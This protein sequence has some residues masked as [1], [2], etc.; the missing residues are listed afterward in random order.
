[1]EKRLN[2][3]IEQY[4][5]EFKNNIRNKVSSL[6]FTET[7]KTNELIEY[8]YDYTRLQ[9]KK[10]DLSKRLRIKNMIPNVNRCNAKRC[11]GEQCTRRRKTDS[12]FCGTHI[13]GTPHGLIL[14]DSNTTAV[15]QKVDVYAKEIYGIMYY[16]DNYGNI[17]KTEDIL[18]ERQNPQI[19]AK[20]VVENDIYKIPEFD[21]L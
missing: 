12:T 6:A 13:K 11:N 10:E 19:I 16:I 4:L 18:E 7:S 9:L 14:S 20:Y 21:I 3:K 17:Y 1:M 15:I 2:H 8:V 5:T